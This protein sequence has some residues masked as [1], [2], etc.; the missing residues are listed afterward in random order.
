[1]L[2]IELNCSELLFSHLSALLEGFL[3]TTSHVESSLWVFITL[4]LKKSAKTF[5][6][7]LQFNKLAWLSREDLTHEEWLG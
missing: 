6:C 4:T 5:N 1:M 2:D 7:V 3:K